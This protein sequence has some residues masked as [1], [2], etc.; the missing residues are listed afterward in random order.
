MN[1]KIQFIKQDICLFCLQRKSIIK[2][3][4]ELMVYIQVVTIITTAYIYKCKIVSLPRLYY[5][6]TVHLKYFLIHCEL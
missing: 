3:A 2:K 1:R 6:P 4:C 5:Y